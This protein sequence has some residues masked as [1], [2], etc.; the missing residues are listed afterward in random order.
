MLQPGRNHTF[1][2]K[3]RLS[4]KKAIKELFDHGSS[5]FL[6]P[7]KILFLPLP[8]ADVHQVLISVS[9]RNFKKAVHRN[10]IK[11]RIRE[12]YRLNKHLITSTDKTYAIAYIYVAK[13]SLPFSEIQDKLIKALLRLSE[14]S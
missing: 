9:K 10:L 11:R 13:E 3:E 14:K 2:K 12:A 5:F 6:F 1:S 7:F 8:N 4:G